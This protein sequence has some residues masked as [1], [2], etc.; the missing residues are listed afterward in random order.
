MLA[1]GEWST[2]SRGRSNCCNGWVE[3]RR[4]FLLMKKC[5]VVGGS[6]T[7]KMG[8]NVAQAG[9]QLFTRVFIDLTDYK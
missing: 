4:V 6:F 7:F 8:I 3:L 5:C 9:D 2:D 1:G